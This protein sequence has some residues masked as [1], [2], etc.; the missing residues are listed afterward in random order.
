M[1]GNSRKHANANMDIASAFAA[2]KSDN[3]LFKNTQQANT[4]AV[5]SA[6]TSTTNAA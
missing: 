2:D 3:R 4:S 6:V 1:S 5:N